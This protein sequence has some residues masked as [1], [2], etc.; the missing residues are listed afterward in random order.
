MCGIIGYIGGNPAMPILLEGLKRL[1]YRGYDSAGVA[2][3]EN[4]S[5]TVEK[6]KGKISGLEELVNRKPWAATVGMAH[7]RWATHGEPN[8]ENAHPHT[9][10]TG[11]IAVVHNGIIENFS[12]LKQRLM[13]EGHNFVT[14]TDT[15]VIAHLI[16]K[17]YTPGTPL[18]E[19][20][21]MTVLQ[22][23]GTYGLVIL[24]KREPDK[25]VGV[26]N[27]SPLI[28]GI[29]EDENFLASDVSAIL[30]HTQKVIYLDDH[31]MV[32]VFRDHFVTKTLDNVTTNKQVHSVDWDLEM[33]EKGGYD[34]FMLKEINE[35]PETITNGMRGRLVYDE[36]MAKLKLLRLV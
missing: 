3:L 6:T 2:M 5:L 17:F 10:C 28:I 4:G 8:T 36:G 14:Q 33:I 19:A 16:E 26:R 21:R 27:G 12:A 24:S 20:V 25:L 13:K 15:E 34:H 22:L 7:T 32:T 9:D 18:E 30:K 1:E 11:D 31:E 29:A 23:D 35:Q